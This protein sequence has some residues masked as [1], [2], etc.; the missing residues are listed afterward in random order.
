MSGTTV[1]TVAARAGMHDLV[2]EGIAL[3]NLLS[4]LHELDLPSQVPNLVIVAVDGAL[5]AA[6]LLS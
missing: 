4:L 2:A 1:A 6:S 5:V 3:R